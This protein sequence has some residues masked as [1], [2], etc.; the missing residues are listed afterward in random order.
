MK[1]VINT[2]LIIDIGIVIFCFLSQERI[3]LINSQI[4]FI[5]SSL[6]MFA[7][8]ISYRN[9]VNNRIN[10]GVVVAEDNK[11]TIEKIEDPYDLYS[12]DEFEDEKSIQDVVKGE[13]ARLKKNRRSV[14]QVT[15]DSRASLSF[16][17]LGAYAILIMGFFYLDNIEMMNIPS[18]LTALALPP[19]IVVITLMNQ[20]NN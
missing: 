5:S 4:G 13:K 7:S 3:W 8:I 12:K 1:K 17:R 16:Y 19:I 9:M 15:K 11:E 14:W 6:V 18:Y 20:R 10:A 2:L